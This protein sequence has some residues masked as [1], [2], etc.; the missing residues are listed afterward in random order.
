MKKNQ[1]GAFGYIKKFSEKKTKIE[2]F[3]QCHSA[4]NEKGFLQHPF[5]CKIEEGPFGAI[6]KYSRKVSKA[7]TKKKCP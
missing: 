7:S 6:Q 5:C 2:N 3:E 1:G 4:K